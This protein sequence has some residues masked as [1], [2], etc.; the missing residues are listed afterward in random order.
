MPLFYWRLE[1]ELRVTFKSQ[2]TVNQNCIA[3]AGRY[4]AVK[5]RAMLCSCRSIDL[6]LLTV[7]IFRPAA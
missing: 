4:R 2:Q 5:T 7:L 1:A 6:A 3:S